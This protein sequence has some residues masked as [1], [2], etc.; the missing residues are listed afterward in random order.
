MLKQVLGHVSKS[1]K[2]LGHQGSWIGKFP[3]D[4]PLLNKKCPALGLLTPLES[5]TYLPL[6]S[7]YWHLLLCHLKVKGIRM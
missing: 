6:F 5:T 4:K 7:T 1:F 2:H 3:V